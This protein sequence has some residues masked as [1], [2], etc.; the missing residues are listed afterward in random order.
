MKLMLFVVLQMRECIAG[1]QDPTG[2]SKSVLKGQPVQ[3][4]LTVH[5][6]DVAVGDGTVGWTLVPIVP[7]TEVGH[8]NANLGCTCTFAR[9]INALPLSTILFCLCGD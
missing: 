7:E 2:S 6:V 4:L 5:N 3:L 8:S 1:V 9:L